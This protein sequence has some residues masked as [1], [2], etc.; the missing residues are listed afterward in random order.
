MR[1][2]V[3]SKIASFNTAVWSHY[4]SEGRTFPWRFEKDPYKVLVSEIM[5]QQTGVERVQTYYAKFLTEYPDFASLAAANTKK[6]L[7]LWQG[8]G[9][10]RRALNLMRAAQM[11]VERYGAKLPQTPQD[12]LLLPGVGPGTAGAVLAYA[13]NT[14]HPFVETNIRKAVISYF[15]PRSKAVRDERIVEIVALAIDKENP[16]EWY[17]AVVDYGLKMRKSGKVRNAQSAHYKK[18]SEFEGSNRQLRAHLLRLALAKKKITADTA[19]R[20]TGKDRVDVMRNLEALAAEGFITKDG[21][22]YKAAE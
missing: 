4:A 8:L 17:Y 7:S 10:N 5:L 19:A 1:E 21:S 16:R 22:G 3:R 15:F 13:F 2:A 18:Q 14:P 20:A 6:L 12:L 9:Y 11:V